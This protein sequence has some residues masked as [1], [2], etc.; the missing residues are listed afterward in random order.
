MAKRL[1]VTVPG[2]EDDVLACPHPGV[3]PLAVDLDRADRGRPLLDLAGEPATAA[4]TIASVT[5][6]R[7]RDVAQR[8]AFASSVDVVCRAGWSRRSP[9]RAERGVR[10]AG[11]PGRSRPAGRPSPSDREC[12][13][14][15]PGAC[16]ASRRTRATTSCEVSPA[17]LSTTTSPPRCGG[18]AASAAAG[19]AG[20]SALLR[21]V[22]RDPV[23]IGVAG[24][25]RARRRLMHGRVG[26]A[27]LGQQLVD[28]VHVVEHAVEHEGQRWREPHLGLLADLGPQHAARA[29]SAA[30]VSARALSSPST[31]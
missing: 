20:P 26:I 5:D 17:G 24:R 8:L 9:C 29:S 31:V 27:R 28:V 22:G 12:R 21:R 18:S 14:A 23:R 15:R 4:A 25:H 19:S 30:A 2:R 13:R 7:G 6:A 10:A 1:T 11:S 3:G 16:P